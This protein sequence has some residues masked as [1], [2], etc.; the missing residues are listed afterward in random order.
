MKQLLILALF[1]LSTFA[2]NQNVQISAQTFEHN[3]ENYIAV[4]LENAP[5]W[6]TYWKNPGDAGLAVN[7][8]FLKD[9]KELEFEEL[10]WP[11]PQ[12][13]EEPGD[14]LTYGYE[15]L[16]HFFY[17]APKDLIKNSSILIKGRWL[18]CKD[19]CIPGEGSTL[20]EVGENGKGKTN[21]LPDV[22]KSELVEAINNLPNLSK[23]ENIEIF[24]SKL[25]E[26]NKLILQYSVKDFDI[27]RIR[28][29]SNIITPYLANLLDYKH[30]KLFFDTKTNTLYGHIEIDWD[31]IYEEPEIQLPKDGQFA[32]PIQANLLFTPYE[33]ENGQILEKEFQQFSLGGIKGYKSF[34]NT[35]TPV[36]K[37]GISPKKQEHGIA[38]ILLFALIGGLILNLMPCVLPVISLKLFGLIVHSDEKKSAIL[39]HNLAYTAG[40]VSTFW[41]LAAVV[42]LL[43][44]SGEQIGWGF[45][46]QSPIFVFIM[47]AV[48]FI[49]ALNMMGLFEF[50]TPGGS[51]LGNV[52]MKKGF[53][54]DFINGVL[55]T[56]LSTPC[57]APFLGTALTFAFTTSNFNIFLTLTFVGIGL[58]LPFIITAIFPKLVSFLPRPGAWMEKLKKFLGLTLLLTFVW[59]YDI[60]S[61]QIDFDYAGIYINTIFV[62]TFFAFFFRSMISKNVLLNILFFFIPIA[63]T[64]GLV[65]NQGLSVLEDQPEVVKSSNLDWQPWSRQAMKDLKGDLVFIDF[66]A[67]WCL[68]CKVNEKLVLNTDAFRA[69]VK[70]N[71]IELL[72]G[73][74]T[75]RDETI[76]S[77]LREH[78]IVGVPAYFIQKPN[79]ELVKLG[80][81]LSIGAIEDAISNQ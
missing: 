34:I 75:K 21:S 48:I 78:D 74:W 79:G 80:E 68:T 69:L 2:Q 16:Y 41:V 17:K 4:S 11:L 60:L 55:A 65:K 64:F 24:L 43:K 70:E 9:H 27:S 76:A 6:H 58:A 13:F 10:P 36:D 37:L 5:K 23:N 71:N 3:G 54:A 77:F 18:V 66:T 26:E 62:M 45:Q 59:L 28:K 39:K 32:S 81:V 57:S 44:S 61:S 49:L 1:C 35:L 14:V 51:K 33:G 12:R 29:D 20:L 67:D 73:D 25:D 7:I 22:E 56:I 38:L 72:L 46:L 30:E 19:I 52:Q 53:M 63:L 15:G 31:G 42:L 47:M 50:V 40:I 8:D